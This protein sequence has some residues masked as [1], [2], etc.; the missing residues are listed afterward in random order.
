MHDQSSDY[1]VRGDIAA[2][3]AKFHRWLVTS[4]NNAFD[5]LRGHSM[6]AGGE[7]NPGGRIGWIAVHPRVRTLAV[8]IGNFNYATCQ[9]QVRRNDRR[10]RVL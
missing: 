3:G 10:S 2:E 1:A 7:L 4:E 8:N 9:S 5:V 6:L